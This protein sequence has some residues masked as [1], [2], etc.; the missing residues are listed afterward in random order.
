MVQEQSVTIKDLKDDQLTSTTETKFSC[1]V[2]G[3]VFSTPRTI[4]SVTSDTLFDKAFK[5]I[6]T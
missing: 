6:D 2:S 5:V 1:Y 4:L 3:F